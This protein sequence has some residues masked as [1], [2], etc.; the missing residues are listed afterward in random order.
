MDVRKR[1]CFSLHLRFIN[2]A[3]A[4]K[5]W[6]M[7]TGL[8]DPGEDI[9]DAA[10]RELVEETG[11]ESTMDG[12]V[13][14]RQ[15]HSESRSSDL[16]FV[17]RMTLKDPTAQWHPQEDEVEDIMWMPVD[18]YCN[19][20]VWKLSPVYKSMNQAIRQAAANAARRS[21]QDPHGMIIHEKLPVGFSSGTNAL[22]KSQL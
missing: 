17:C 16:F 3:A 15:A 20:D 14:F 22:F 5:L 10:V 6:K 8:L 1:R 12:I 21:H 2:I 18:E 11:L 9:P 13:C 7:P 4:R 19:Q